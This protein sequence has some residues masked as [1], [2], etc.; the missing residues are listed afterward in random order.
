MLNIFRD[1]KRNWVDV[2]RK[3]NTMSVNLLVIYEIAEKASK[4][5]TKKA[6]REFEK[7]VKNLIHTYQDAA[8]ERVARIHLFN[9]KQ[10]FST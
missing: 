8:I 5:K 10:Q 4:V 3:E 6:F 9:L 2:Q 1:I 7:W